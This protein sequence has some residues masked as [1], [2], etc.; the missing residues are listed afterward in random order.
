MRSGKKRVIFLNDGPSARV[1]FVIRMRK[2]PKKSVQFALDRFNRLASEGRI[3]GLVF[4]EEGQLVDAKHIDIA[5]KCEDAVRRV[6]TLTHEQAIRKRNVGVSRSIKQEKTMHAYEK[7]LMEYERQG[8]F[9]WLH[10]AIEQ[11]ILGGHDPMTMIRI[12]SKQANVDVAELEKDVIELGSPE[13]VKKNLKRQLIFFRDL[14]LKQNKKELSLYNEYSKWD[15]A[16]TKVVCAGG[17]VFRETQALIPQHNV[18]EQ[19]VVELD[20]RG[21]LHFYNNERKLRF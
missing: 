1:P 10:P 14:L 21:N 12:A 17:S 2:K 3:K 4:S 5:G 19:F 13:K 16:T 11:E 18:K 6:V 8:G 7:R 9:K 20:N 15:S